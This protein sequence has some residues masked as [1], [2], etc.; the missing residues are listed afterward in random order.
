MLTYVSDEGVSD[1]G[2]VIQEAC[3]E[4]KLKFS[5]FLRFDKNDGKSIWKASICD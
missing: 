4:T 5:N 3:N 1:L 2:K